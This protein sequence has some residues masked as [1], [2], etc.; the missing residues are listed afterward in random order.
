MAIKLPKF[1][2]RPAKKVQN[3]AITDYAIRLVENNKSELKTVTKLREREIPPHIIEDGKVIDEAEFFQFI[4]EVVRDWKLTNEFIRFFVPDSL[5]VMRPITVPA[6]LKAEEVM[7]HFNIEVGNTVHVP[8]DDPI[9]DVHVFPQ[10]DDDLT[11]PKGQLYAASEGELMH[12]TEVFADAVTKPVSANVQALSIYKYFDYI[13]QADYEKTYLF[14]EFNLLSV[15]ISIFSEN[16]LE[17]TRYQRIDLNR[18]NWQSSYNE[19]EETIEWSYIGEEETLDAIISGQIGEIEYL[20]DF[21]KTSINDQKEITDL[22]LLGD[23][24]YLEEILMRIKNT[25][26]LPTLLLE[27]YLSQDRHD[28]AFDKFVP[29][30]GLSLEGGH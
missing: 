23:I 17:F 9:I 16:K 12:Y 21:Y 15:H 10:A 26:D 27:G 2:L 8:F 1:K 19:D 11:D 4:K 29:A 28:L 13:Y 5:I 14:I 6:G 25:Y 30:L 22:I 7:D 20:I 24:P 3:I 18:T